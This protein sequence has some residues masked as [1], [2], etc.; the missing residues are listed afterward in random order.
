MVLL[1]A[2][3]NSIWHFF[4]GIKPASDFLVDIAT[5]E[6]VLITIALPLSFEMVARIADRYNADVVVRSYS[7]EL[8]NRCLMGYLMINVAIVI[9]L[10][11]V[12]GKIAQMSKSAWQWKIVSWIIFAAFVSGLGL[13][14]YFIRVLNRYVTNPEYLTEKLANE[15]EAVL[16][17]E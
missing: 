15:A 8:V 13:F 10:S 1:G 12:D 11:M 17:D 6:G 14:F 7:K 4:S 16:S 3:H 2:A 9:F 5:I